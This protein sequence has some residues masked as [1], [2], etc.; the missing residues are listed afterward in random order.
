[1]T[2]WHYTCEHA[3]RVL[4]QGDVL[5]R[6][7][8]EFLEPKDQTETGQFVWVTDLRVPL[9]N[10]LGLT[11]HEISCDRTEYRYRILE[12]VVVLGYLTPTVERLL[13][14]EV[15]FALEVAEGVQ[16]AHWFVSLE[17]LPAIYDPR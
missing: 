1:M 2:Y 6:P 7:G 16:P 14:E 5:L 3:H 9:R 12:P 11:M 10:P 17:P 15:R 4:Q 13:S 8:N